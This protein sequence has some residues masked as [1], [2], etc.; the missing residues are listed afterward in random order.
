MLK[1]KN[2]L[3]IEIDDQRE[4][5]EDIICNKINCELNNL[6]NT[7]KETHNQDSRI[8]PQINNP[9]INQLFFFM[10]EENPKNDISI[11]W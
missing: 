5:E 3:T 4:F 6:K 8:I 11:N 7:T 1:L 2:R 10:Q 9:I